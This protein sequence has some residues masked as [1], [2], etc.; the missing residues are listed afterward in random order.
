MRTTVAMLS[1]VALSLGIGVSLAGQPSMPQKP[2]PEHQKL[3]YFVGKWTSGGDM[4]QSPFGPAGKVTSTD[5]CEWFE[6]GFAVI[7]RNE[8]KGPMGPVKGIGIMGYDAAQKV[9]TYYGVDSTAMV[10]T[11]V[12]RG[13]VQGDTW[14]YTDESMMGSQTVKSRYVLKVLSPTSYSFKWETQ[15]PDGKWATIMEGTSRKAT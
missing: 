9:Y 3:A 5:A 11:S 4:K 10:M 12:P 13:T 1:V 8:G 14:T 7:C 15:G 6:G 2:T